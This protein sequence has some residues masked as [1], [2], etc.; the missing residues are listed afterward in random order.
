DEVAIRQ[1]AS[2]WSK[3][4]SDPMQKARAVFRHVQD[5]FKYVPYEQ[6]FAQTRSIAEILKSGSAD[7]E[8]KAI[9]L[10]AAL[11]ALDIPA[12]LALVIG[13]DKGT[14]IGEFYSLSQFS[15]V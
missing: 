6:V 1:A 11:R 13:K 2:G 8:E 4:A 5:D 15:H 12:N 7:N 9:L 10:I 3:G 14:L